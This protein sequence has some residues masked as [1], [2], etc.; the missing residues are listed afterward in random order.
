MVK[1]LFFI[2]TLLY[3]GATVSAENY[4]VKSPDGKIVAEL[5]TNKYLSLQFKYN[6]SILLQESSIGVTLNDGMDMG[7]NPKV[8]SHKL[9]NHKETIHAP[10]YRQQNFETGY[11]ELNLKLKNG[12]GIILR[13]YDE[14]VAYRF[15]TQRKGKTI[16]L[17]ETAAYQFGKDKK[18]WLPYTTTPEKPFAMAFQ[19]VYHETRL[20]TAKQDLAFLP[21]TIDCGK[22]KVTILE[23]DLEKYPGMWLKANSSEQDQ[24]KGILRAAFA[25]YPKEM[26]YYPWRHMSHVKSA[27]DYIAVSS[28]K[29]NYPWRIFAITE[30]DTQMPTNN[31]VYALAAP[32]KIG[33]TSWIKPGKVAWDWWN[34][35]GVYKVDFRA[36]INTETY[37]YYI[38]FAHRH[39][40]EYILLDEGWAKRRRNDLFAI[41]PGLDVKEI[42]DYGKTKGVGVI[43]WA[44]YYPFDKDMERV[45]KHYSEMGVKGFKVDFINSD[46]ARIVDFHYR[47]AEMT[48]KYHLLIDFHGTY[49]PTGLNR[50]YPNVINFEG[51]NGQEQ[52]KW[53]TI[54]EYNQPLYDV[55]V[56]FARM[57]AGPMDYTQGAMINGTQV[58]YAPNTVRPMSQGTRTHQLAQY[59]VFLS[60]LNMLCDSPTHYDQEEEC[61]RFIVSV[62]TVWDETIPLKSE[63]GEYVAVARRKDGKWFVGALTNWTARDLTLDLTPLH[64]AGRQADA[65]YDGINADR[66]AEDYKRRQITI[67]EDGKLKVHLAPG[68]GFVMV[69]E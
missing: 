68:G 45:C 25:P 30:H 51:V 66:S 10:F 33:D 69:V 8:A 57:L 50:T 44:G 59:V 38:D 31:L 63:I 67:P 46:D 64:I 54:K 65:F 6:G 32:N 14:G 56:P 53:C 49:K 55:T 18:A 17:N 39:G 48:A 47:A 16:I 58:T 4:L 42:V 23:S 28:G 35:W 9:S 41:V 61:T 37:K 3:I 13:A 11:Q 21:A 1:K 27:H 52:T 43:L 7:K 5:N 15:Y 2:A 60:P 24:E 34:D 40:I 62:P 20:D 12:F 36:G 29:R 26:A 19:N 22:A